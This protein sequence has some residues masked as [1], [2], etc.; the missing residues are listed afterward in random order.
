MLTEDRKDLLFTILCFT[1]IAGLYF[2]QALLSIVPYVLLG[3]GLFRKN[4][5]PRL[6]TFVKVKPFVIISALLLLYLISGLNSIDKGSWIRRIDNNLIYL[7]LPLAFA[8]NAPIKKSYLKSILYFFFWCTFFVTV[9]TL[10]DYYLNF[11]EA[12]TNYLVGKTIQTP[13]SHPRF[14]M[15]ITGSILCGFFLWKE[16]F[17]WGIPFERV[18]IAIAFL[19]QV[20]F[21]HI[22]AV[23]TGIFSFYLITLFAIF[24][25]LFRRGRLKAGVALL[26][27]AFTLPVVSYFAFPSLK[28]KLRYVRYDWVTIFK[29]GSPEHM[30]DNTRIRSLKIGLDLFKESPLIGTGIGDMRNEVNALYEERH[31][32]MDRS[33][34]FLPTNQIIFTL[35]GFGILGLTWF[36]FC[37][38]Y[39]LY[40]KG[41]YRNF[42]LTA[43]YIVV[44][45]AFIGENAVE[46]ILGKSFF[47]IFSLTAIL[48]LNASEKEDMPWLPG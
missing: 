21:L 20:L 44:F 34:R 22:L 28:N 12:N 36:L 8:L 26:L 48:L 6:K 23:R 16:R 42:F 38:L 40:Y 10:L 25:Y 7:V 17:T 2:S 30:S 1:F 31:P 18:F 11:D 19:F 46:L 3:L 37:L 24:Y 43:F 5:G 47:L 14:S 29:G 4:L 15:F 33:E 32:Q 27:V 35:T 9:A 13:I 39:P 41:N 45:S